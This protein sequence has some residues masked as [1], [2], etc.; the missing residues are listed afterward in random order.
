MDGTVDSAIP[1]SEWLEGLFGLAVSAFGPAGPYY[2]AAG[3]GL[4]T[5]LAAL[6]ILLRPAR[7]PLARI[8][9]AADRRDAELESLRIDRDG[10]ALR[11][12]GGFLE[13]GNDAELG[14]T[15]RRLIEAGY[16]DR[17]S[18]RIYYLARACLG[19]GFLAVGVFGF[20]LMPAAPNVPIG[21]AMSVLFGFLGYF[22]PVWHVRR[23]V[24]RRREA[25]SDDF[26]DAMD[27]MLVCIE[28]GQSLEQAMARVGEELGRSSS[29][30]AREFQTV[31]Y[32]FRA[33]KERVEVLRGL[34]ERCAVNDVTSF[35]TVLVQSM[36]FGTSVSEALRIYAAEMRDKRLVRAEE[37][38]NVLPTKLTLGTMMFTVPP[39][40]LILIGPSVIQIT[41]AL[42]GLSGQ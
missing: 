13:P 36:A 29:P 40:I 19:V 10:G 9:T 5:M 1:G 6:P 39:L 33:G 15:R 21:L 24:T 7:D 32:E 38:A 2:V 17:A 30:L 23:Q 12:L 3:L 14:E 18:V 35:V 25:I 11:G 4:L 8:G 34:A 16:R 22:W 31:S 28:G 20:I 37:A 26:P 41:R 27:M 42:S